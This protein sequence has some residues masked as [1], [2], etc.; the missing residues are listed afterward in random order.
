MGIF[1]DDTDY[2]KIKP[3]PYP[4]FE[5][6]DRQREAQ[7]ECDATEVHE[8]LSEVQKQIVYEQADIN[9]ITQTITDVLKDKN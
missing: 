6:Q 9:P 4:S 8:P 7:R 5:E 2:S 1:K 3:Q